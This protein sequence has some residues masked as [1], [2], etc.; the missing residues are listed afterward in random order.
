MPE[1]VV[2]GQTGG[3]PPQNPPRVY[4]GRFKTVEEL[5]AAYAAS[6]K[7]VTE[8][9]MPRL[10]QAEAQLKVYQQLQPQGAGNTGGGAPAR[11]SPRD[12]LNEAMVPVDAVQ[13]LVSE[14]VEETIAKVLGPL[15]VGAQARQTFVARYPDYPQIE[16]KVHQFLATDTARQ[17]KY[18]KLM[19]GGFA[20]EAYD[21]AR[22]WYLE[23]P[24]GKELTKGNADNRSTQNSGLPPQGTNIQAQTGGPQDQ[25]A[26]LS[27]LLDKGEETGNYAEVIAKRLS[28]VPSFAGKT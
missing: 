28:G 20:E 9:L 22:N 11:K 26:E 4:A 13:A 24:E 12:A 10:T 21:L 16:G 17:E 23:S 15:A 14:T 19:Q 3:Q 27:A 25:Q 5:E 2:P 8:K 6:G 7:E 1:E 18:N